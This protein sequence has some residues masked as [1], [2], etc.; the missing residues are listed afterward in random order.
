MCSSKI[1]SSRRLK[2]TMANNTDPWEQETS[3]SSLKLWNALTEPWCENWKK[4]ADVRWKIW[5]RRCQRRV[6]S[7]TRSIVRRRQGRNQ[8]STKCRTVKGERFLSAAANIRV[9]SHLWERHLCQKACPFLSSSTNSQTCIRS[10]RFNNNT[11]TIEK[12][13]IRG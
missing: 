4:V 6:A 11:R 7:Q 12:C 3:N 1:E 2:P 13:L 5:E 9:S 8:Q 10:T